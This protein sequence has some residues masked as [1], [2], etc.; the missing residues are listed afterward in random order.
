[1]KETDLSPGNGIVLSLV[2]RRR[3]GNAL[4]STHVSPYSYVGKLRRI[5]VIV[6]LNR[7]L[8]NRPNLAILYINIYWLE[9]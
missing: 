4:K 3:R 6:R 1:M 2:G 8:H 9:A 5:S 7:I